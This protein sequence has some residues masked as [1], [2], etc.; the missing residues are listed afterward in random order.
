[1]SSRLKVPKKLLDTGVVPA[2]SAARH[3]SGH[4]RGLQ[5]PLARRGR[6]LTSPNGEAGPVLVVVC[7]V[8]SL[9]PAASTLP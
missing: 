7:G 8:P 3:A 1:M 4:A 9:P 2:I 6:I 5:L